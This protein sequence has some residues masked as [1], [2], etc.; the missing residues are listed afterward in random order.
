MALVIASVGLISVPSHL[1]GNRERGVLKRYHASGVPVWAVLGSQTV[2]VLVLSMA[3][4]ALLLVAAMIAHDFQAPVSYL[5]V[6]GAFLLAV[7]MFTAIGVLLGAVLPTARAA[8]AVGVLG[9]F[10]LLLLG[11]AGPPYEVMGRGMRTV[12]DWT[13]LRHVVRTFHA[14]WLGLDAGHSSIVVACIA[15]VAGLLALRLFRWE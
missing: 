4:A 14:P 11:G 13:P 6:V 10:V 7:L 3:S 8:Q 1:A 2:V 12:S 9:W 15:V 5:G